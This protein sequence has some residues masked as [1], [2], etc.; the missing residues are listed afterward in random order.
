MISIIYGEKGTGKTKMIVDAANDSLPIAKGNL[1]FI[2]KN[3]SLI[4]DV[5][6]NIRLVNACEY[7]ID[8]QLTFVSFI[9]GIL[10]GNCDIEMIFID[11]IS[12]ITKTD[13]D[14]LDLVFKSLDMLSSEYDVDFV[15]TISC[16]KENLPPFISRYC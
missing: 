14:G 15:L 4:H 7:G 6:H 5:H 3:N 1:I 9:K 13:V 2:D 8:S 11:G 10:A 16:A 12:K